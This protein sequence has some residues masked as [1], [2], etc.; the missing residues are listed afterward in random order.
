MY[1]NPADDPTTHLER[2]MNLAKSAHEIGVAVQAEMGS[3]MGDDVP[4]GTDPAGAGEFVR[5]T[6]VEALGISA[7]NQHGSEYHLNLELIAR[8]VQH[9]PVP[10]VLHGGSGAQEDELR[11]A[12][13]LG[14]RQVNYSALL[15]RTFLT[16]AQPLL[17]K[18]W[19][20]AD[21]HLLLGSGHAEDRMNPAWTALARIVAEKCRVLGA[22]G[23]T[24]T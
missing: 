24:N 22:A 14:I 9:M 8:L 19:R 1:S 7:G 5:Q 15:V 23:R 16:E 18:D 17:S 12:V 13:A 10:L 6:G 21:P 3:L 11:Q 20:H 2:T 4:A